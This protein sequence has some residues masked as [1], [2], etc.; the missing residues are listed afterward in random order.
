[1]VASIFF[2]NRD[3]FSANILRAQGSPYILIDDTIRNQYLLHL[4][5]KTSNESVFTIKPIQNEKMK[6]ILPIKQKKLGSLKDSNIPVF[7]EIKKEDYNLGEIVQ[8]EI[9]DETSKEKVI[10]KIQFLGP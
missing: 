4:F 5:N 9:I 1:M 7:V 8:L 6:F 10:T 3:P 2:F